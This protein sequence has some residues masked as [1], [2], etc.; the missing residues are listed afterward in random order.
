MGTRNPNKQGAY[1]MTYHP[2]AQMN[3]PIARRTFL[4]RSGRLAAASALVST[5]SVARGAHAAGSD[6]LRVGLVGC[7]ARGSGAAVNALKADKNAKLTAMADLFPE[8]IES[9]LK[10]LTVAVGAQIAVD[11]SCCYA[12]FDAG[13]QLIESDV[14]V[15]LL[16]EPPHFR[17]IHLKQCVDAGKH[18][19][20][21]K[22][23]AVDAPGV[24][25]VMA[26]AD[27]ARKKG[28]SVVSGLMFRYDPAIKETIQRVRDGAVGKI[29]S[30]QETFMMG[31]ASGWRSGNPGQTEMERQLRNWYFYTWLSGDHNVEQHVHSLDKA[32]WVLGDVP[33]VAAW[34]LGGRQVRTEPKFGNIYDHH[35]VVYEYASGVRVYSLCRQQP[36]CYNNVGDL[37]LGS[38][39]EASLLGHRIE[40]ENKWRYQGPKANAYDLEHEALFASI[41]NAKPINNGHYMAQSTLVGIMGRMADYSGQRVTWEQAMQSQLSLAPSRYAMDADPPILPE[42]DGR[43]PIAMPG[44]T[45][46]V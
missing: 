19:F 9:S 6:V 2:E 35:A 16:A 10:Q 40:G 33:P 34:G 12:G 11:P 26:S 29:V 46:A 7:G 41:R 14:D 5:L 17:P 3:E 8:K 45:E 32:S 30:L 25:S 28:L 20:A 15:V 4:Q 21:E 22:P 43:Y 23:V 1:N 31:A 27:E 42:A 24:R 36:G 38:K 37:V 13:K 39:G 18:V 44:I